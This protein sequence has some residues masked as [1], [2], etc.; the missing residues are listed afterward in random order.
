MSELNVNLNENEIVANKPLTP[1]EKKFINLN[2]TKINKTR[3]R[4]ESKID[5]LIYLYKHNLIKSTP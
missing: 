3:K 5:S 4:R 1:D 2:I